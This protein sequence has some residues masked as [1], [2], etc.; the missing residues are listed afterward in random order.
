MR[1]EGLAMA[2]GD[3]RD[4]RLALVAH[5]V[6]CKCRLVVLAEIDQAEQRVQIARHVRAANDSANAGQRSAPP[7][8]C[9]GCAHVHAGCAIPSG[10][11]CPAI[12]GR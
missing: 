8:R 11:A 7:C 12:G 3:D 9:A 10:A 5:L 4:D 6:D 2:V 1:L